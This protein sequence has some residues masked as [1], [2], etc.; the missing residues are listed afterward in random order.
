[1]TH[2]SQPSMTLPLQFENEPHSTEAQNATPMRLAFSM[3]HR[4]WLSLL[5]E[6]WWPIRR[7][8]VWVRLGINQPVQTPLTENRIEVIAWIDPHKLP[9]DAKVMIWRKSEWVNAA[10][11]TLKPK[12]KQ[13][14]WPGPIPLFAITHFSVA[15]QDQKVRLQGMAQGFANLALP[16][17]EIRIEE[18]F[19]L[20]PRDLKEKTPK[21]PL[22]PPEYWNALR[23]A[24]A[25][26]L[27]AV[28]KITP[29]LEKVREWFGPT[30]S[31]P[32]LSAPWLEKA[33]WVCFTMTN[34]SDSRDTLLWRA[35]LEVFMQ[36]NIRESW[37]SSDLLESICDKARI[38]GVDPE[39]LD[40]LLL[41]TAAILDDRG[42]I[43]SAL[44]QRDPLGLS[45]QLVLL[46][47]K[48]E[49]FITWKND[50][51]S[52]PP[53]VWWSAAILS[54][55][56]VGYRNLDIR[57]R[58][59]IAASKLAALHIWQSSEKKPKS[60]PSWNAIPPTLEL[61]IKEANAQLLIGEDVIID[62][63]LS[64]RGLWFNADYKNT[65][66]LKLAQEIAEKHHTEAL[67]SYVD[68]TDLI[69]AY[70]GSGKL[71][72][73]SENKTVSA[74]GNVLI[75]IGHVKSS[76]SLDVLSFKNWIASGSISERLTHPP[77][78]ITAVEPPTPSPPQGLILIPEFLSMEEE[79]DLI[80]LVDGSDWLGDLRRRVQH[81]GWK[82]DY[83][84]RSI[85]PS[86]Y[87]GPLPEWADN[88]ASRLV[89]HGLVLEKPDQV[90]V[91]EYIEGQGI[92]KH[93]D[94]PSCFRGTIV[95][96]SLIETWSMIFRRD[97]EKYEMLL[98]RRSAA[99]MSGSS[100]RDW[101]H[102]IPQRKTEGKQLRG[103][104]ISLTFRKVDIS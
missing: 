41:D 7:D 60:F 36:S 10:L 103:R 42:V 43:D 25:M 30:K 44:S 61:V 68:I 58:D 9:S 76:R 99:C 97:N 92:S 39:S 65:N 17:Q 77:R 33:P 63:P 62:R 93:I 21:F 78:E 34:E 74:H 75:D 85:Q 59:G 45:L 53:A 87:L 49:Q 80:N 47:P 37:K 50:L 6:E 51:L 3:D 55:L 67:R 18:H 94:C 48:P 4:A 84:S 16:E 28:P 8:L 35:M 102:E 31:T 38:L 29:W 32:M 64:N 101:T 15:S 83:R 89:E 91:N 20:D 54:G 81:Y 69:I 22:Q 46:R 104:R 40:S 79:Q 26:A 19:G 73:D 1:M 66:V 14:V 5:A 27:W 70:S 100:R 88:L 95:T 56:I 13:L 72:V 23:G 11:S 12:D 96:L 86:S 2:P 24:A 52:I 90:I 82:Y 98:P 71:V 57:F